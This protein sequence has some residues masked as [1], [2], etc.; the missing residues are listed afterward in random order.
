M[1]NSTTQGDS[2][3]TRSTRNLNPGDIGYAAALLRESK[4]TGDTI[5]ADSEAF[6]V[7][8]GEPPTDRM[9][10]SLKKHDEITTEERSFE[11]G[12]HPPYT[13]T[14]EDVVNKAPHYTQAGIEPID[15]IKGLG[16]LEDFCIGNVIK[17]VSR[18]KHKNGLED[19]KKAQW[20]LNKVVESLDDV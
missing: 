4:L 7:G 9:K 10:K 20:Y 12:Y 15:F 19:L 1:T 5:L 2:P 3:S 18:Y 16:L 13:T 6:G 17:Y 8:W 11:I 14:E